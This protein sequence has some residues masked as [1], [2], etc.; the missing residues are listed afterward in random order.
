M[1][2]CGRDGQVCAREKNRDKAIASTKVKTG[3]RKEMSE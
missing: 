3:K 1:T 2:A